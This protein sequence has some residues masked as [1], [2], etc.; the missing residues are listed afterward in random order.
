MH[1]SN[2][3]LRIRIG[4]IEEG[5]GGGGKWEIRIEESALGGGSES[6]FGLQH[7]GWVFVRA[8]RGVGKGE[9]VSYRRP[10]VVS[11]L[12]WSGTTNKSLLGWFCGPIHFYQ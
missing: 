5:E 9:T 11:E 3:G 1:R 8:S 4:G 6:R 7:V 12:T 10:T 2:P